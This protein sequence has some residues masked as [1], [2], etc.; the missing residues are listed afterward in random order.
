MH[1][2]THN[3]KSDVLPAGHP[4]AVNSVYLLH[5]SLIWHI[6]TLSVHRSFTTELTDLYVFRRNSVEICL[7]GSPCIITHQFCWKQSL[8]HC[9]MWA[10]IHKKKCSVIYFPAC[11]IHI[12]IKRFKWF[13]QRPLLRVQLGHPK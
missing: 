13:L 5:L 11:R 4:A 9:H 2:C 8:N 12:H 10:R 7:Q 1:L 3:W 6:F